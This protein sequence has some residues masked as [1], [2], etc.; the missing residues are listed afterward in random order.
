MALALGSLLRGPVGDTLLAVVSGTWSFGVNKFLE[1]E[2]LGT[3][4]AALVPVRE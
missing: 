2:F 4:L 1:E 3:T